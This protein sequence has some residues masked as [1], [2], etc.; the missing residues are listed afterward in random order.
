ME[1]TTLVDHVD[2]HTQTTT[3]P[4]ENKVT[5]DPYSGLRKLVQA[6]KPHENDSFLHNNHFDRHIESHGHQPPH[7]VAWLK[8]I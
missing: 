1:T 7:W 5:E 6:A 4:I 2:L 3:H 8:T